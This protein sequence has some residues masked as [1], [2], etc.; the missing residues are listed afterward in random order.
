[1]LANL[2]YI[3]SADV[4]RLPIAASFEPRSSL[5]GGRDGLVVIRRL[6]ALLPGHLAPGGTALLEIGSDQ[7][8][9]IR[10]AVAAV[11][12]GWG[13]RLEADLSGLPRVAVVDRP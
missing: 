6:L 10:E 7:E 13:C 2:P 9:A 5:D 4:E 1:V 8:P 12:P 11:L 3:P